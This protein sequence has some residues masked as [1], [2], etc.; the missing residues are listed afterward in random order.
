MPIKHGE[1]LNKY[2]YLQKIPQAILNDN[3]F[4]YFRVIMQVV[5]KQHLKTEFK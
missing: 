3:F 2:S 4:D 5:P 1:L